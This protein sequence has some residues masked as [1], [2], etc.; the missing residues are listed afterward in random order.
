MSPDGKLPTVAAEDLEGRPRAVIN[1]GTHCPDKK[2]K[3]AFPNPVD[4]TFSST[5]TNRT[6]TKDEEGNPRPGNLRG[7]ACSNGK[8][9]DTSFSCHTTLPL[10]ASANGKST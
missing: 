4:G 6:L 2:I 10:D 5:P 9:T 8:D 1:K 7:S 3:A